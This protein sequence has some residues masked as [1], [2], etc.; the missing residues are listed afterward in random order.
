M[1]SLDEVPDVCFAHAS[2]LLP[3]TP[4][5]TIKIARQPS[6]FLRHGIL[7]MFEQRESFGHQ[8]H[9]RVAFS[10]FASLAPLQSL[11]RLYIA[12]LHIAFP[13]RSGVELHNT[14]NPHHK[15]HLRS[16]ERSMQ[17]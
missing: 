7:E 12:H 4:Q 9:S 16:I 11:S 14:R 3:W 10:S 17:A 5:A 2:E 15:Q 13:S 1:L 8:R 6:G